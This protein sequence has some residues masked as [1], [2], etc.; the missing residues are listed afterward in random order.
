MLINTW[1]I[2]E[3]IKY[4]LTYI[5]TQMLMGNVNDVMLACQYLETGHVLLF[6]SLVRIYIAF[7]GFLA[8]PILLIVS[9]SL[10]CYPEQEAVHLLQ[11]VGREEL[12]ELCGR[13]GQGQWRHVP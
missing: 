1:K 12:G 4:I 7:V 10:L 3:L 9:I 13:G 5:D 8:K 6:L 2:N 11:D